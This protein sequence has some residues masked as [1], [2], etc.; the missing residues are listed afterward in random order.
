MKIIDTKQMPQANGH[1]SQCIAYNEILYLSGQLPINPINKEIPLTIEEQTDLALNNIQLIL[2]EAGVSKN[3]IIQVKLYISHIN[4]WDKVN[5]RYR[6]FF[7]EHKPV[8]S[9]I[10]TRELHFG[11]LIEIEVIAQLKK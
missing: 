11:C 2:K 9:I 10:P 1:Y 5:E 3:E 6:L 8:R 7:E 4:L